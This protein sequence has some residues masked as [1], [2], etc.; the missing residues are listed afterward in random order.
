MSEEEQ[1]KE[2]VEKQKVALYT[3]LLR[4]TGAIYSSLVA[5]GAMPPPVRKI[6]STEAALAAVDK[7]A[8][9]ALVAD[10]KA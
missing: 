5:T 9:T 4:R 3:K 1:G 6:A 10:P 2:P 8:E 7:V